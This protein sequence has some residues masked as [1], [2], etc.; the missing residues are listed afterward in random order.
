MDKK[1]R[2]SQILLHLLQVGSILCEKFCFDSVGKLIDV[3]RSDHLDL[4]KWTLK[5]IWA[6]LGIIKWSVKQWCKQNVDAKIIAAGQVPVQISRW[7]LSGTPISQER[8]IST[9]FRDPVFYS[10]VRTTQCFNRISN[11]LCG[12]LLEFPQ[13]KFE[14]DKEN[15]RTWCNNLTQWNRI[16][17]NTSPF[18]TPAHFSLFNIWVQAANC[19]QLFLKSPWG[20]LPTITICPVFLVNRICRLCIKGTAQPIK[21]T[22]AQL[23]KK[24]HLTVTSS[25]CFTK[26]I[27]SL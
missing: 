27:R 25:R 24:E 17:T 7:L 12:Q 2:I 15:N 23:S 10:E 3:A 18:I 1:S 21:A 26:S 6:Y 20:H 13:G 8:K 19:W 4:E 22:Y 5:H 16:L 9:F 11:R 14:T